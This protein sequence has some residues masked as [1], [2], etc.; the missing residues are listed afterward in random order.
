[1]AYGKSKGGKPSLGF[2]CKPTHKYLGHFKNET[3]LREGHN[4]TRAP[5]LPRFGAGAVAPRFS[6]A[7][8]QIFDQRRSGA[9]TTYGA[10]EGISA[11]N[12]LS[13]RAAARDIRAG[14]DLVA[15][16]RPVLAAKIAARQAG[17]SGAERRSMIQTARGDVNSAASERQAARVAR[18]AARGLL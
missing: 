15:A 6:T 2:E 14:S 7:N 1:M 17:V 9:T 4:F 11:I 3:Y 16:A 10:A 12:N 18:R 8:G 13:R 5:V